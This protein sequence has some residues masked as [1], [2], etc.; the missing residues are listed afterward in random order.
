[1]SDTVG[2]SLLPTDDDGTNTTGTVLDRAFFAATANAINASVD[3]VS[4]PT[5][6]PAA[7][8]DEVVTARGVMASLDARLRVSLAPDGTLVAVADPTALTAEIVAARDGQVD[9][10][11][12]LDIMDLSIASRV[13]VRTQNAVA[14]P[15]STGGPVDAHSYS[16]AYSSFFT[17][18]GDAIDIEWFGV[19]AA[20][21]NNK[22][23]TLNINGNTYAVIPAGAYNNKAWNIRLRLQNKFTGTANAI[24]NVIAMLDTAIVGQFSTIATA[25][26]VGISIPIKL[27][28]AV[29]T[30]NSD[31]IVQ[32]SNVLKVATS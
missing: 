17:L 21:G 11:T 23:V 6:K 29:A 19:T 8:T 22:A 25:G 15:S 14:V 2:S 9:L 3:S 27:T 1:M 20:N 12:R 32:G 16:A 7:T 4:N 10:D 28:M 26:T 5:I 18:A 30:A 24:G 31:C 13:Q